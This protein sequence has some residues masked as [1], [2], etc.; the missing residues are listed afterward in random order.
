MQLIKQANLGLSFLLELGLLAAFGFWGFQAG[1]TTIAKIGLCVLAVL[2]FI[3]FWGIL[4]APRSARRLQM[5]WYALMELALFGLGVWAL[6]STGMQ[7]PA[8]TLGLL[9]V[10]N[11]IILYI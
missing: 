10:I 6:Y 7:S 11:Q 5:P 3:L 2:V 9:F 1:N 8:M 4:M